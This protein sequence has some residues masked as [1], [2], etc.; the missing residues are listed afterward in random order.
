M[1]AD[2][3]HARCSLRLL[4]LVEPKKEVRESSL[5]KKSVV[6]LQKIKA[7]YFLYTTYYYKKARPL[8]AHHFFD[9]S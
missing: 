8:T 5:I 3:L 1:R 9:R 6:E 2:V 7:Q 4:Q